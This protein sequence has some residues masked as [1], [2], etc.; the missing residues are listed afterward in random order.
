[1]KEYIFH[2]ENKAN[3]EGQR[4]AIGIALKV[5]I[6]TTKGDFA[7]KIEPISSKKTNDQLA[8][9]HRLC[10]LLAAR[11]KEC[12]G[13]NYDTESAKIWVKREFN[14]IEQATESQC[15]AEAINEKHRRR[16]NGEN[17]TKD[18]F[19]ELIETFKKY[20]IK[21]KS[22][23]NATK[24]EMIHLI[25]K[26]EELGARMGWSELQ[27]KSCEQRAIEKYYGVSC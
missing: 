22:F 23:A 11:L 4:Q 2:K 1:M 8:G 21:P 6:D 26:I 19:K 15:I 10:A 16:I 13:I 25:N 24:E 18:Q 17:L 7:V 27:L 20:L 3:W 14:F 9:I 12:N 5:A